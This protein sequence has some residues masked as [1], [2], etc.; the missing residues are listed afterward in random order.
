MERLE[1]IIRDA[2]NERI[3]TAIAVAFVRKSGVVFEITLGKEEENGK[4]ISPHSLFDVASLTKVMFT[5][6]NVLKLAND[7]LLSLKDPISI[8]IKGFPSDITVESLLTHTSGIISWLPL[9]KDPPIGTPSHIDNLPLIT[10]E[11]AVEKIRKYGIIRRPYEKVEYS[12]LNYILLGYI[13]E[14]VTGKKLDS[15]AKEFFSQLE[16]FETMFNPKTKEGVVATEKLKGVVHDENARSLNG[17]STN[18]GIFSS[19]RDASIFVRMLLNEGKILDKEVLPKKAVQLMAE[20]RT[21]ELSPKRTIGWVW[22]PNFGSAPDFASKNSI[23]HTGFTGTSMFVDFDNDAS[24][25]IFTN[26]VYYGREN[27]RHL[28]LQRIISN[29]IYGEYL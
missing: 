15:I 9:Y 12:C 14:I 18:A 17:V 27:T 28:H 26:R 21:G 20:V 19:I 1:K 5:A 2:I 7:G 22:G 29:V 8:Y 25:V 23:G 16:M 11:E 13:M 6:P 10:L 3:A 4:E 24:I